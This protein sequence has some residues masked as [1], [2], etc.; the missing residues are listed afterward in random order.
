MDSLKTLLSIDDVLSEVLNPHFTDCLSDFCDG[1]RYQEHPLFST[2]NKAL[3]IV[4]YYDELEVVNPI[5]SYVSK[6]KLGCLF[7]FLGNIRPQFRSTLKAINLL[8][9]GK[10]V[11][12]KQYG[13]DKFF[14]LL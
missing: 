10:V 12:I 6:Q 9:V 4:G 11:D 8:A 13:I 1:S 3:Q 2:D 5:G 14:H 7:F